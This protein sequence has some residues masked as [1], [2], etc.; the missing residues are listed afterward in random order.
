LGAAVLAAVGASLAGPFVFDDFGLLSDSAIASHSGW[1]Q[2]WRLT[3][4]RPL[5]WFSFWI[6]YE[7]GGENPAGYHV[8]SLALHLAVCALLWDVLRRLIPERA[9]LIAT[10]IFALHP[11]VTE[12]VSYIFARGT[13][14]ASLF[15][16]LAIRSWIVNRHLAATGWF[17]L[18]M[19]AKEECAALPVFLALLDVSRGLKLRLRPLGAMFAVAIA[20]GM[21]T[22]WAAAVTAGS[23]AGSQ[24]GIS[25]A[26]Y[27]AAEGPVIVRY[28]RMFLLPWGFSID[29]SSAP[30][31]LPLSAAAWI[32]LAALAV[33]ALRRFKNL[34]AGFWFIAALVL[35]APSSSIFPAADLANDRRMYLP[36]IAFTTCA[37][38]LLQR[39]DGRVL[40]GG[41]IVLAA[42]TGYYTSLWRSPEALWGRAL[43]HAPEK[44]R[45]RLQLARA[46]PPQR[47]LEI[48]KQADEI[49]P[50]NAELAAERGRILLEMN[51][52]AEALAAFGRALA[53]DPGDPRTLNNR[54]AALAALGQKEA[55][56]ADFERAL[57]RDPCLFD[58]RLN[59][60][61]LGVQKPAEAGCRYTTQQGQMLGFR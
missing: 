39:T 8:V 4:T 35:L 6:S 61:R 34:Q 50:N 37:G 12:P 30:S 10:T 57:T 1:W 23:Q 7:L 28:L 36:L 21:R 3:Q 24:A 11:L 53:L 58:A 13:L 59:L 38:L 27:L 25:P 60:M 56:Q 46:V 18:A 5:T 52:P 29:Y 47:G 20:L 14:L 26:R 45:P 51:R 43:E 55:A 16:L 31:P 41:A 32:A 42:I 15:S 40:A 54:G 44:L 17:L 2:S 33:V 49:A 9:A 19:L 48:L 22:I